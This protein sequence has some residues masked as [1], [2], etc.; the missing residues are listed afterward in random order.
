MVPQPTLE[1]VP[2]FKIVVD[3]TQMRWA[4]GFAARTFGLVKQDCEI[5]VVKGLDSLGGV[6]VHK[7]AGTLFA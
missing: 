1:T 7:M 2:G 3:V 4:E 5:E 6:L